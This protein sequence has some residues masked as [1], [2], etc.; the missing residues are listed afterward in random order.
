MRGAGAHRF[1]GWCCPA[2]SACSPRATSTCTG[3]SAAAAGAVA[4]GLHW[5][6]QEAAGLQ[7]VANL[8]LVHLPVAHV[9]GQCSI[10]LSMDIQKWTALCH[11]GRHPAISSS[12]FL[13]SL[14]RQLQHPN[15]R[16]RALPTCPCES[17][18]NHITKVCNDACPKAS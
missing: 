16:H 10:F 18:G 8:R 6:S 15:S 14:W 13:Q 2:A 12:R 17:F 3:C 1:R 5:G 11:T 7:E 4:A 9:P